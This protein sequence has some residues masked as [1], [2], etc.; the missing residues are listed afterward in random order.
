MQLVIMRCSI[1]KQC[2]VDLKVGLSSR[3]LNWLKL[4]KKIL[5]KFRNIRFIRSIEQA[6]YTLFHVLSNRA[7]RRL[8]HTLDTW[9][10]YEHVFA[11]T[12]ASVQIL[13]PNRNL[14]LVWNVDEILSVGKLHLRCDAFCT[15]GIKGPKKHLPPFRVVVS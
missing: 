1:T 13:I 5:S 10:E 7:Q 2:F 14:A 12:Y 15:F 8:C 9:R 11:N 3:Y 6:V 4:E